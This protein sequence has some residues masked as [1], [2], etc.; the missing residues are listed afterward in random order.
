[1]ISHMSYHVFSDWQDVQ[2]PDEAQKTSYA[3]I[4]YTHLY[5]HYTALYITVTLFLSLSAL[6]RKF[7]VH[8]YNV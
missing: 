3:Y 8:I 5:I 6:F 7:Q 4:M 2:R 1:M